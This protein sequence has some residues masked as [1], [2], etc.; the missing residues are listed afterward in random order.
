MR[1][2]SLQHLSGHVSHH[3]EHVLAY[4]KRERQTGSVVT[5]SLITHSTVIHLQSTI[6]S[7]FNP[8]GTI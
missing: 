8:E 1:R 2:P 6:P 5:L 4:V 7:G 3:Q